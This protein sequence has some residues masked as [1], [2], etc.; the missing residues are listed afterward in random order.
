MATPAGR[1]LRLAASA[2]AVRAPGAAALLRTGGDVVRAAQMFNGLPYLWA[3]CSGFGFNCS[4]L[5]LLVLRAHGVI[6]TRDAGAQAVKGTKVSTSALRPGDLLFHA[7]H[8]YVQHVSI[9]AGSGRMA[10]S[11]RTGSSVQTIAMSTPSYARELVGARR[12]IG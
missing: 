10:Q 3:G 8:G 7:T 9:Y 12:Y 1:V 6:V 5:T 4:G 11:P 2:V